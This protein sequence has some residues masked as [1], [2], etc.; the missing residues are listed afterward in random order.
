MPSKD[1][2]IFLYVL[3]GQA[4]DACSSPHPLATAIDPDDSVP[5]PSWA[6]SLM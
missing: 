1:A 3:D 2:Q 6:S 4:F 5:D